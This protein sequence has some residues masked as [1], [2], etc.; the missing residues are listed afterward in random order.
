LREQLGFLWGLFVSL[1]NA[2]EG[3]ISYNQIKSYM[4]IYGDLTAFEVDLIR[5][6][7]QLSF[8]EAHKNG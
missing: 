5:E 7:D 8:Q 6:L 4:D 1:K 2:S 3:A